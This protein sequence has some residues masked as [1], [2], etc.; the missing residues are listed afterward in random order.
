M[1]ECE[2]TKNRDRWHE[3][4][5]ELGE[6]EVDELYY[7][8]FISYRQASE[9]KL[10]KRLHDKLT[11][12][13]LKDNGQKLRVFLDAEKLR[14][15][16][17]WQS[18]F[19]EALANS[20][21][22]VPLV[23]TGSLERMTQLRC[24]DSGAV[25]PRDGPDNVL[26]EWM[27]ALELFTRDKI[28]SILPIRMTEG[29]RAMQSILPEKEHV[30]TKAQ[31]SSHLRKIL[32]GSSDLESGRRGVLDGAAQTVAD[33][34]NS[35]GAVRQQKAI[36]VKG[37]VDSVCLFQGPSYRSE[38]DLDVCAEKIFETVS[39]ILAKKS[40]SKQRSPPP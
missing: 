2:T 33:A 24:E 21:V 3:T 29:L 25:T 39:R 16:E 19:M 31:A 20:W 40:G 32:A 11:A 26:C 35:P 23:S 14:D 30:P 38:S 1:L 34:S 36:T 18:A 37:V 22:C 13:Q 6:E 17:N 4:L 28:S 12:M 27:S 7:H 9:K 15:G 10:A 8:V 5:G